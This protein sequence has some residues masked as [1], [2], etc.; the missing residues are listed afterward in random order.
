MTTPLGFMAAAWIAFEDIHR[1]SGPLLYYPGSHR[2]PYYFARHVGIEP[3]EFKARQYISY[4]EKYEPFIQERVKEMGGSPHYSTA[5][6]GDVLFWHANLVHGGS[7]RNALV[8]TRKAM[9]GH[10]SLSAQS[11]TTTWLVCSQTI[12]TARTRIRRSEGLVLRSWL[13]GGVVAM[14]VTVALG[15]SACGSTGCTRDSDC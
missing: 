10:Y 2:W 4:A 9:V 15:F 5:Q 7:K 11:A 3:G 8:H 6:K 13:V 14:T 12:G 1:D